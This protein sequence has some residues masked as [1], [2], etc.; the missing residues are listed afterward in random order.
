MLAGKNILIGVTGGIAAYKSAYL[1]RLLRKELANVRVM[2]TPS[3]QKFVARLTFETLSDNKA[4]VDLFDD[5]NALPTAHIE[6]AR[7]PDL[8]VISPATA[9]T[10]GKIANGIADNIVTTT[11]LAATQKVLICP[12]MN[13]EMYNSGI[14]QQ[15]IKKLE[16]LGYF[17]LEPGV[18]ELA[19]GEFGT[20]RLAEPEEIVEEI[21]YLLEKKSDFHGKKI[22]VTA[23]PT[24]EAID[25]VRYLTNRSSGKMG[26]ALAKEGV[27]RGAGVTLVTGP[28]NLNDP[29]RVC[30][31]KVGSAAEMAAEVQKRYSENDIIVMAAAVADYRLVKPA[32]QKLKKSESGLNLEL[33]PTVDILD[34]LGRTKTNQFLVG[35]A[36]ETENGASNALDKL[37]RKRCDLMVLNNILEEGAGFELDTNKVTIFDKEEHEQSF[38]KMSK[39]EVA[40]KIFDAVK[41]GLYQNE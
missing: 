27:K 36:L 33:I 35:F 17:I 15:N 38:P 34:T 31:V 4:A 41:A 29:K 20:G 12:A 7:W 30:M 3:A 25:P 40:E 13:V 14:Y 9:N 6:W 39:M 37:R 10:I 23:G 11:L 28:T 2:M 22:L 21:H 5:D 16:D 32:Q 26:Y 1:V 18:G 8:I 19:C 24:H